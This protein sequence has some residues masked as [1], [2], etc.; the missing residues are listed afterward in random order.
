MTGRR[1]RLVRWAG[2]SLTLALL[3][4][5]FVALV[6][7]LGTMDFP[8][9]EGRTALLLS[10]WI[11]TLAYLSLAGMSAALM[12]TAAA[13][14]MYNYRFPLRNLFGILLAL[15]LAIPSYLSASAL[16]GFLDLTGPISQLA[17]MLVP[18]AAVHI[19]PYG[20]VVLGLLLGFQL[21]PYVYLI[22]L[23]ALGQI[24]RAHV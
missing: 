3:A 17:G 11:N 4:I 16:V 10:Y 5:P 9:L 14:V 8:Y 21:Y 2:G 6:L 23:P 18:G 22:V 12:G 7:T 20:P 13:W 15:P 19:S 24:G 1:A